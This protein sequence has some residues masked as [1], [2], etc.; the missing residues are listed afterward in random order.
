MNDLGSRSTTLRV[1]A[2]ALLVITGSG[3]PVLAEDSDA[4][5]YHR[6]L[7]AQDMAQDM[8]QDIARNAPQNTWEAIPAATQS[9]VYGHGAPRDQ[10]A[11]SQIRKTP[12]SHRQERPLGGI[13][14]EVRGGFFAHDAGVFGRN[15]EGGNDY[16]FEA[17]F[18]SPEMFDFMWSPRPM[19]GGTVNDDGDTSQAY[20]G[21]TWEWWPLNSVFIDFSFGFAVHDGNIDDNELGRKDLGSRVLFRESLELGWNFYNKDRI[22]VILDHISH[23]HAFGDPNEGMDSLGVRYGYR[24]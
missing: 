20:G 11:R 1:V 12:S 16:N 9:R 18:V 17:L 21:L 8:A 19:L 15:K 3:A 23:G 13:I 2:V 22:S 4:G 14:S 6:V 10:T 7:R 24:F 5:Q